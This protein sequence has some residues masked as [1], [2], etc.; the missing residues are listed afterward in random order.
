[1]EEKKLKLNPKVY[2]LSSVYSAAYV[3]LD[4]AYI[5]LDGDPE[6]E[7]LVSMIAKEE[8][9]I[10]KLSLEFM[11][12]L[13]NYNN[14]SQ[15]LKSN[16]ETIKLIIEKALFSANPALMEETEEKEIQEL[17]DEFDNEEDEEIKD[18]IKE[19]KDEK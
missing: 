12:E 8:E 5:L 18:I 10:E 17:I 15:N 13:I 9:D 19:I 11:N 3:F 1:M 6:K 4:R 16:Q 14:Y 2:P 7:I